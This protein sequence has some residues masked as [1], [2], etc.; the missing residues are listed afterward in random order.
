MLEKDN[1]FG[2]VWA[3]ITK[4]SN[5]TR[6]RLSFDWFILYVR[7]RRKLIGQGLLGILNAAIIS[8]ELN[9]RSDEDYEH[10]QKTGVC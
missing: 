2:T 10:P 4:K 8:M 1:I 7:L 6:M 5:Q 9:H 3:G